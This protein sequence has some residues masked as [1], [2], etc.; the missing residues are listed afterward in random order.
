M[1]LKVIKQKLKFFDFFFQNLHF[2]F[3]VNNPEWS[4]MMLSEAFTSSSELDRHPHFR[5]LKFCQKFSN[6]MEKFSKFWGIPNSAFKNLIW[7]RFKLKK[8][9][10][11]FHGRIGCLKPSYLPSVYPWIFVLL[12]PEDYKCQPIDK[13][14]KT[15]LDLKWPQMS[16]WSLNSK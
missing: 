14:S 6:R 10:V 8:N 7:I 9:S 3:F 15:T 2:C 5:N 13:I 4:R 1:T 11:G 16:L 12:A